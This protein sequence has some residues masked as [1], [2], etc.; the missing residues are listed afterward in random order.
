ML[1]KYEITKQKILHKIDKIIHNPFWALSQIPSY[2]IF[3]VIKS[4]ARFLFKRLH[5]K[6]LTSKG[7]FFNIPIYIISYNRFEYLRQMLEWLE[8]CGYKNI[9]IIDNNSNY[10]PLLEFYKTC[11]YNVIRMKKNYGHFVFYKH[12]RFFWKRIL[13]FYIL[14]DPD[15][16][17]V[18]ECPNDFVEQFVKIMVDYPSYYKVGFSLRIDDIP[19]D[20]YLKYEVLVCHTRFYEKIINNPKYAYKI[21]NAPIDTT[22]ALNSPDLYSPFTGYKYKGLRTGTPYQLRHLP[23]YVTQRNSE[24]ENYI[25]TARHDI[26]NWD[27]SHSQEEVRENLKLR[28]AEYE[29]KH[30][31]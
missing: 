31:D 2:T 24:V 11:P 10:E 17:L 8:K 6:Y 28:I 9:T 23:W 18:E 25:K 1:T 12:I 27:G 4:I 21:Y 29:L 5:L 14:T 22:F 19:D 13:S 20:Y 7:D 15:L 3:W 16:S 30:K 26:S